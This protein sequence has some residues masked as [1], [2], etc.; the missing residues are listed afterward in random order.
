MGLFGNS[1]GNVL[2]GAIEGITGGARDLREAITGEEHKL[3]LAEIEAAGMR[4]QAEINKIE[5]GSSSFFDRGWRPFLGW[6]IGIS[7]MYNYAARPIIMG[8]TGNDLPPVDTQALMPIIVGML[9]LAGY[10]T[11]EKTQGIQGRH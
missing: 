9:G 5:A 2:R 8:I 6:S 7:I 11:F 3:K 4:M 1:G 10:R